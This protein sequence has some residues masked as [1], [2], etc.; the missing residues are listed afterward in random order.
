MLVYGLML[1]HWGTYN[2]S[3]KGVEIAKSTFEFTSIICQGVLFLIMGIVV[4]QGKWANKPYNDSSFSSQSTM[5][6]TT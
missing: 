3:K 1:N 4:W 2:M 6:Y 5:N